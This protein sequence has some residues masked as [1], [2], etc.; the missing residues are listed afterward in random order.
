MGEALLDSVKAGAVSEDVINERVREILRVRM[1]IKPVPAE[2]ANKVVTSQP[3]SQKIA[4][5][6]ATKSI[7][8]LKN[9]GILPLQLKNKPTIAV[10]GENA[11]RKT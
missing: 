1:A 5:E 2:Q 6:V 11:V 3:E 7:V 8:L 9:E 10:I 4:Y